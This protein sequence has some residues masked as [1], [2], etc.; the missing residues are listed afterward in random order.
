MRVLRLSS[1]LTIARQ[2]LASSAAPGETWDREHHFPPDFAA[3]LAAPAAG[4]V[5]AAAAS[6]SAPSSS[7]FF[8]FFFTASLNTRT[9]GN[10]KGLLPSDQRSDSCKRAIRSA[11]RSTLRLLIIP[12]RT[13]RLLSIVM[14]VESPTIG[15]AEAGYTARAHQSEAFSS[16]QGRQYKRLSAMQQGVGLLAGG[17]A[18]M[19]DLSNG[20]VFPGVFEMTAVACCPR[21]FRHVSLPASEDHSVWVRC[22]HCGDQYSLQTAMDFVPPAL[23]IVPAPAL[24]SEEESDG[25]ETAAAATAFESESIFAPSG[26]GADFPTPRRW[27]PTRMRQSIPA[28]CQMSMSRTT[29]LRPR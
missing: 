24:A 19:V 14:F 12:R 18:A 1:M 8:F 2:S 9:F 29:N 15:C 20:P 26:D 13:R 11:R 17:R 7:F 28:I 4:V 16:S 6:P 27:S 5:P 3:G 25:H 22:P 23:E 10:P 21:C